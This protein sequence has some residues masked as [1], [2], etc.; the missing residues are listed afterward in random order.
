MKGLVQPPRPRLRR[1]LGTARTAVKKPKDESRG[2][3]SELSVVPKDAFY[4]ASRAKWRSWLSKNFKSKSYV[5][6]VVPKKIS[7]LPS[8]G[9]NDAVEE[10]LCFGWIDSTYRPLSQSL[11]MQRYTPRRK[12]G[13]NYSQ[14][15]MERLS[16]VDKKKLIHPEVRPKIAHVLKAKFQW[17]KDIVSAVEK[18][19]V[20]R[21]HWHRF[22]LSYRRIRVAWVEQKRLV[23]PKEFKKRLANLVQKTK[24]G[25]QFGSDID[26]YY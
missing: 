2:K 16:W 6:L 7:K 23:D 25:K 11:G 8:V 4:A 20:S 19:P 26:K 5:W 12:I 24:A 10:A 9:Y 3:A 22:N 21:G 14:P 17:P 1:P 15:N 13:V 18:D